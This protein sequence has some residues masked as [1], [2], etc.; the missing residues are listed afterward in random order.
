M[1]TLKE[2][3]K[4]F[5]AKCS[6]Q[7]KIINFYSFLLYHWLKRQKNSMY[8]LFNFIKVDKIFLA[9][10]NTMYTLFFKNRFGVKSGPLRKSSITLNMTQNRKN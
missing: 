6:P 3:L 7:R 8:D 2:L 4:S 5:L 9:L 1:K 10:S